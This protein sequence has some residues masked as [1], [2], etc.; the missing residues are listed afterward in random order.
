MRTRTKIILLLS[1]LLAANLLFWLLTW[2][3][4]H[5]YAL[6]LSTGLL[7]YGFGLRHAVDADHISA[8]DNTTR[9]LMQEGKRPVGVGFFFSL[10]HSTIVVLLCAAAALSTAYIESHLT[11][12]K[13]I[14]NIVGTIVSGCFLYLIGIINLIV[15]LDLFKAFRRITQGDD[16]DDLDVEQYLAQRGLI[17]RFFRPLFRMV[18]ASW[19]MYLIGFLFGLGFDT[20]TEVGLLAI[21]AHPGQAGMPFWT[22]MLL[23]A[24]FTAGMCLVDTSDGILM[25]GAYGWAFIKPIR[26]LYYNLCITLL[27]VLVAFVVGTY[28]LLQVIQA[29]F[30]LQGSFWSLVSRLNFDNL[31]F[32]IIGTF[33]AGWLVSVLVYKWKKYETV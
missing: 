18:R 6:L 22:I 21:A 26:K 16:Y 25:L 27:S 11:H 20:A 1:L 33:L 5:S 14:G 10:G 7:A 15:M 23:P 13:S 9:K 4:S 29:Q 31:G 3:A 24:L 30:K 19:H 17:G 32:V 2:N 28:E 12:W 8:I